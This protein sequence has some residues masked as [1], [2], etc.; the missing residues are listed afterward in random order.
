MP[1]K[2]AVWGI[3]LG[4]CAVKAV[5]VQPAGEQIELLDFYAREHERPL[6]A[7]DADAP[8]LIKAS[9]EGLLERHDVKKQPVVL[10]VPSQMTLTRFAKLPPVEQKRIADIVENYEAQQQ[11]P[12]DMDEVVWDYEIFAAPEST[13]VEAGI[14]AIRKELIRQHLAHFTALGIEPIA[15]QSSALATYNALKSDGQLDGSCTLLLDIGAVATDLIIAE[16]HS[17][18]S[19][20]VPMG[21]NAF[22]DALVKSFKLSFAKAEQ[23][24]RTASA[25]K[26]ARQIMQAMRP[27]F[28]DLLSQIQQSIGFYTSTRRQS[29]I[30]RVVGMGRAFALPGL[31]K[32]LT[33]NL[34]IPVEKLAGFQKM[35]A[36][37]KPDNFAEYIISASV[38]YGAALQGAG[39]TTIKSNLL[40]TEVAREQMWRAKRIFFAASAAC[41][42]GA[43]GAIWLGNM[44]ASNAL[45]SGMGNVSSPTP[46][47]VDSATAGAMIDSGAQRGNDAPLEYAAKV[48]GALETLKR[49]FD[50]L[51]RPAELESRFRLISELPNNNVV[52]PQL[53]DLVT[54]VL[55]SDTPPE[56][57]AAAGTPE[58][59]AVVK[60]MSRGERR[61]IW[62]DRFDCRFNS[63]DARKAFTA[64]PIRGSEGEAEAPSANAGWGIIIEGRTTHP[65]ANT[66][67]AGLVRKIADEGRRPERKTWWIGNATLSELK[68]VQVRRGGTGA[69]GYPPPPPVS[70]PRN[71]GPSG[72]ISRFPAPARGAPATLD[73]SQ[74]LRPPPN[75][76]PTT[77]ESVEQDSEFTI[78]LVVTRGA[79]PP[80]KIPK[81]FLPA[82]AKGKPGQPAADRPAGGAERPPD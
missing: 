9:L 70:N 36:P 29:E 47:S 57:R 20:V 33:Q 10:T 6:T 28:A 8:M 61:E 71:E 50:N 37:T 49:D 18:W 55:S 23:L 31:Q 63:K 48:A 54:R 12:F 22:T 4:Q 60:R 39:A 56:V 68:K 13:D 41:V 3:D 72:P 16:G 65:E 34:Q 53:L 82:G 42:A 44:L 45:A 17:L 32:F 81:E 64:S 40:P 2:S 76:D 27:V 74:F 51:P 66:W 25:S 75:I 73:P 77:G 43:A 58:Y 30:K 21:G 26:Y 11:I 78:T 35:S 67:L 59:L 79:V 52:V 1:A 46:R 80:D 15:V 5:R 62:I 19:R 24:K 7:P 14:F 69:P 38:A